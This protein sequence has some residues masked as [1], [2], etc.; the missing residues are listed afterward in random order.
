[1]TQFSAMPMQGAHAYICPKY[2]TSMIKCVPRRSIQTLTT[3]QMTHG[4][5]FMITKPLW[6]LCQMSQKQA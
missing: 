4:G 2:E 1:M 5:Q 6:H 3:M